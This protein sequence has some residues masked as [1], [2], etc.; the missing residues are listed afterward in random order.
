MHNMKEIVHFIGYL[1][2]FLKQRIFENLDPKV[3]QPP[4]PPPP[5]NLILDRYTNGLIFCPCILKFYGIELKL[6]R[7]CDRPPRSKTL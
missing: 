4:F 5:L 3:I 7:I 2:R 6:S 1:W